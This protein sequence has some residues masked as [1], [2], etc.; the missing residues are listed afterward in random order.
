MKDKDSQINT[1]DKK[2]I[3]EMVRIELESKVTKANIISSFT[4][5][6]FAFFS[7]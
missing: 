5:Q 1:Y 3:A 6:I 4:G 2:L 7:S